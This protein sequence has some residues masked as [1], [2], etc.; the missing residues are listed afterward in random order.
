MNFF[1]LV[2]VEEIDSMSDTSDKED[3]PNPDVSE[4]VLEQVLVVIENVFS[5]LDSV[6]S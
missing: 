3:I 6:R 5:V 4:S 1:L 2:E